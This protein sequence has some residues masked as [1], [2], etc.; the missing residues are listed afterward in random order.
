MFL[1]RLFL[2][3][4]LLTLFVEEI[5]ALLWGY[6]NPRDLLVI[7]LVNTLTN[8]AVTALRYLSGQ[9]VPSVAWRT[10]ILAVLEIAVLFSEWRLFRRFFRKGRYLFLFSLILNGASFGAGFLVPVLLRSL[11]VCSSHSFLI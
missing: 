3:P 4:Y 2:I 7:L 1:L 9:M 11:T 8:P 10:V 6:R 5:I